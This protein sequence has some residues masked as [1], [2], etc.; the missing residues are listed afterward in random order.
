MATHR[1]LPAARRNRCGFLYDWRSSYGRKIQPKP[2]ASASAA[3]TV[4]MM[5]LQV[6]FSKEV[7]GAHRDAV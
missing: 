1:R 4:P 5:M 6:G 7:V 2:I 3:N